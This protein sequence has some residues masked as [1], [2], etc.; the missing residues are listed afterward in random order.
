MSTIKILEKP[1]GVPSARVSV[2]LHSG[3]AHQRARV[4]IVIDAVDVYGLAR[5]CAR[6]GLD[7]AEAAQLGAALVAW[8]T[9]RE[10]I[11][12]LERMGFAPDLG[13]AWTRDLSDGTTLVVCGLD[14]DGDPTRPAS[15]D[16]PAVAQRL[17]DP[18]DHRTLV[19]SVERPT[20]RAVLDA[21]ADEIAVDKLRA[22]DA[23]ARTIVEVTP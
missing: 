20:L 14:A 19:W 11:E 22:E 4:A 21:V 13:P 10:P 18:S 2:E 1:T 15:M 5:P 7:A 16:A 6:L 3:D 8:A 12:L 9:E 23:I 17:R